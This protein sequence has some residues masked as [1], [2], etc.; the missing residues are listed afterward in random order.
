MASIPIVDTDTHVTEPPDLWTSRVSSKWGDSIPHVRMDDAT[1]EA[2]GAA[3]LTPYPEESWYIGDKKICGAGASG[4]AGWPEPSPSHPRSFKE[5][6]PSCYDA[7]ER[8]RYMDEAGVFAEVLFPNIA[9]LGSQNFLSLKEPEL[10]LD[11]VRAYNDFLIEEW[12]AVDRNRLLP[13][14]CTP[15]WDVE[16][17]PA[18]IERAAKLGHKGIVFT[19]TPQS[20]GFPTLADRHWDPIWSA[21]QD[22]RL[23]ICFHVGSGDLDAE[24]S[25]S[26]V[27]AFGLKTYYSRLATQ[28]LLANGAQLTDLLLS[29]ILPRFPELKFVSVESGIGWIPFVLESVDYHFKVSEAYKEHPEFDLL[30]S[31]YFKRQVYGCYWFEEITP[32]YVIE[33]VGVDNILFETDF[34]HTTC[35]YGKAAIDERISKGLSG[36][37]EGVQRK[38]LG[39]NAADLFGVELS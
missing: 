32:K 25:P 22:C 31:E 24:I 27:K 23:P 26:D 29:G 8:L 19:G 6:I 14:C 28:L 9:G 2:K 16:K 5:V 1:L 34:P 21:A 10:M 3:A 36:Q 20:H 35:L 13:M 4:Q 18:E 33:V 17:A 11:C 7:K 38:I 15:F 12:A 30:P 39:E 37:S